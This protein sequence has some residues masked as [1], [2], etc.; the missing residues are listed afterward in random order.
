MHLTPEQLVNVADGAATEESLPHL[1]ACPAC[2]RQ[3]DDLKGM[4]SA[5]AE[6]DVANVPEPSPMF[7]PQFQQRLSE[8]IAVGE[9]RWSARIRRLGADALDWIVRPAAAVPVAAA[10]V[11]LLMFLRSNAPTLPPTPETLSWQRA[12]VEASD[13][14]SS[15]RA[16]L[17][18]DTSVDSDA[19]LQLVAELTTAL[20]WDGAREAGLAAAGSAEH[21]VTHMSDDELRE[22][23]RLLEQELGS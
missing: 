7:W 17:L 11:L 2:R 5:L 10:L 9:S 19:S 3:L 13:V 20:D 18:N 14:A 21:A 22:L 16:E 4:M 15:A 8:R 12:V 23:R 6:P 1:S